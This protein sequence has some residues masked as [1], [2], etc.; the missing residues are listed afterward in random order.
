MTQSYRFDDF[1][2]SDIQAVCDLL[3]KVF[4]APFTDEYL[5]WK[6]FAN[7]HG[8]SA[9]T[10]MRQGETVVG[11]MGIIATRF[12]VDGKEVLA[13]Q[14]ADIAISESHRR[15]DVFIRLLTAIEGRARA[16]EIRFTYGTTNLDIDELNEVLNF[17]TPVGLVPRLARIMNAG[18]FFRQSGL[19]WPKKIIGAVFAALK[20]V[21]SFEKNIVL[22]DGLRL[23]KVERFD[24]RFDR[25]WEKMVLEKSV[26]AIR[27]SEYLNRRIFDAPLKS[28]HV[29]SVENDSSNEIRG[30]IALQ[31]FSAN[32]FNRGI[33]L[34]VAVPCNENPAIFHALLNAALAWFSRKKV[35]IIDCWMVNNDRWYGEML[36][37]GFIPKQNEKARFQI[38]FFGDRMH[39]TARALANESNWR[40]SI[41]DSDQFTL[42]L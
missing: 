32:G 41:I 38:C 36:R 24:E 6:Y 23:S 9:T 27:N 29:L 40:L 39:P 16:R 37:S 22:P 17:Q 15:L 7:P 34:D 26:S 31:E 21:V 20:N 25:L 42:A 18:E 12:V 3:S 35:G 1:E 13:G 30:F 2:K 28:R 33:I 19:P 4:S 11:F 10:V 8:P 5:S 14:G